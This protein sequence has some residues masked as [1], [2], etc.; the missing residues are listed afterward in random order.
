MGSG[1]SNIYTNTYGS[2]ST[3]TGSS[4]VSD[5]KDIYNTNNTRKYVIVRQSTGSS[6]INDNVSDMRNVFPTNEFGKFG[7]K[8]KNCRIIECEDPVGVSRHFYDLIG[9]GG[10][11]RKQEGRDILIT[12]LD[13][14]AE[15]SYRVI[16]STKDSP[17]VFINVKQVI[18]SMIRT[19]KIHFLR[20]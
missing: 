14:G 15:I 16:T 18:N 20:K 3:D 7:E 17:S 1:L 5:N 4:L 10:Q 8:G 9:K 13:D 19:Q 12:K 6:N 2:R 11:I